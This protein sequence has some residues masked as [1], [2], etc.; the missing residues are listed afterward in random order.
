MRVTSWWYRISV[1]GIPPY[2]VRIF[3]MACLHSAFLVIHILI[4]PRA[5]L[6]SCWLQYNNITFTLTGRHFCWEYGVPKD[7]ERGTNPEQTSGQKPKKSSS[8]SVVEK[9]TYKNSITKR[10]AKD[11]N[12]VSWIL[13]NPCRNAKLKMNSSFLSQVSAGTKE[14]SNGHLGKTSTLVWNHLEREVAKNFIRWVC[15]FNIVVF[16][17]L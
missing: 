10:P 1:H 7:L 9:S 2:P 16:T 4:K 6:S 15:N 3:C 13:P 5:I 11:G 17:I 12:V 14:Q 8:S